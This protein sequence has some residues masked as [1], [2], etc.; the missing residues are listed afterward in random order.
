MT[1]TEKYWLTETLK[2]IENHCQIAQLLIKNNRI[3][4][5]PTTLEVLYE[6][7]QGV[8]DEHCVQYRP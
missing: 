5:L 4:L 8:L 3:E 2:T 6:E 1:D 7:A